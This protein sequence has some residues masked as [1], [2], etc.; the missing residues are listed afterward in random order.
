MTPAANSM[1]LHSESTMETLRSGSDSSQVNVAAI[2]ST[3]SAENH[4][5]KSNAARGQS[6]SLSRNQSIAST[7][8]GRRK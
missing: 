5:S 3:G 6:R 2:S 7:S 1:R 4:S 8:A